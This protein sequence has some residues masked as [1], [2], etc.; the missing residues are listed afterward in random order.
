[1]YARLVT[2]YVKK[3]K[4]DEALKLFE[5]SVIP[6]GK[7]QEGYLGIYLLTNKQTGKIVSITLWDTK[8]D[9]RANE[10]SGYFQRQV[11]KFNDVVTETPVKEGYDVS[12]MLSKAR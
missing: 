11:E 8:E 1:M 3:G 12:I 10:E 7:A 6:E 4:M 2:T 9:A 5:D